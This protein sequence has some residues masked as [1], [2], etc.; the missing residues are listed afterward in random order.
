MTS[1]PHDSC[2]FVFMVKVIIVGN[3]L[4]STLTSLLP[5]RQ[6]WG[7]HFFVTWCLAC[8]NQGL[9]SCLL[10]IMQFRVKAKDTHR[11]KLFN[12]ELAHQGPQV[13]FCEPKMRYCGSQNARSLQEKSPDRIPGKKNRMSST[14]FLEI[15]MFARVTL[16]EGGWKA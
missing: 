10:G 4:Y 15:S 14:G 9:L 11:C 1:S 7:I 5:P 6:P 13:E 8:G 12:W 16:S 2:S 3:M